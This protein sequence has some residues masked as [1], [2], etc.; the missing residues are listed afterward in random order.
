MDDTNNKD[1]VFT[2]DDVEIFAAGTWNGDNYT[3]DDLDNMV[4]NFNLFRDKMKVPLKLGH[5]KNQRMAQKDGYPALGWV[6]ELKRQGKKLL[7]KIEGIPRKVK[8][9]IERGSYGR[10]S[11]EIYWNARVGGNIHSRVLSAVALLGAD[12]PAVSS[13]SDIVGMFSRQ[14]DISGEIKVYGMNAKH[15]EKGDDEME[16]KEY[17]DRIN[18]LE[19]LIAASKQDSDRREKE[20]ADLRAKLERQEYEAEKT[21]VYAVIDK[22][23]ADGKVAPALREKFAALML[24]KTDGDFKTY[25]YTEDDAEKKITFASNKDLLTQIIE[26]MP[27]ALDT[28]EHSRKH[29]RNDNQD[30]PEEVDDDKTEGGVTYSIDA[31]LDRK[32]KELMKNDDSLTYKQALLE[33]AKEVK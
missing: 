10:F 23:I 16:V 22:G 20:Y 6:T 18:E 13:I 29:S 4:E 11:A 9:L 25:T 33:A 7:A 30:N 2:R 1:E 21:S 19:T 14:P 8:E 28:E 26:E 15:S 31:A 3:E 5:D 24:A 27:K 12:T 17:Q 32:A